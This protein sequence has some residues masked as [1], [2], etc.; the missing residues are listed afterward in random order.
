[1]T[2]LSATNQEIQLANQNPASESDY[3]RRRHF[4]RGSRGAADPT[5]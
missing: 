1:M 4:S 2:K 5:R 3:L